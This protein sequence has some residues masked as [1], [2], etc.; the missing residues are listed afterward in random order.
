MP[1]F[2]RQALGPPNLTSFVFVFRVSCRREGEGEKVRA[3]APLAPRFLL[4]GGAP[5]KA[6]LLASTRELHFIFP[7][8]S[9]TFIPSFCHSV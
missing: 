6:R 5:G 9:L 7:V 2:F 8:P 4:L 3:A 1:L